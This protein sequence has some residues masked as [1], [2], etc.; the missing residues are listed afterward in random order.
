MHRGPQP[1]ICATTD[2]SLILSSKPQLFPVFLQFMKASS[3]HAPSLT[4]TG[5]ITSI[6]IFYRKTPTFIHLTMAFPNILSCLCGPTSDD[7]PSHHDEKSPLYPSTTPYTDQPKPQPIP[8]SPSPSPLINDILTLLLTT[9]LPITPSASQSQIDT[10]LDL[11]TTSWSE[12]LAEKILRALS[13]LLATATDPQSRRSWGEALSQAYDTSITIA[14]KLFNDLIEYVKGHP[15]EI[16]ATVLL[17][18]VTF[19]VLVRLAPRVLVLLGFSAEGPVEGSWAAWFQST[20][21]GY[22]PKGS[23]MSYLQRLGM[24]WE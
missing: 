7:H 9:P 10:T 20:Y 2:L 6:N 3:S 21:G 15:Y 24:T 13:D 1:L 22:V 11:H 4:S 12:Y 5:D 16:A 18:L 14:E 8:T 17:S 23:L 19:G